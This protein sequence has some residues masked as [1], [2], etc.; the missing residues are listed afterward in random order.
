MRL[1][2]L[3][4]MVTAFSVRGYAQRYD[5]AF[6]RITTEDGMG[7]R[8]NYISALYQ[9]EKGFIWVGNSSG[10]Q[11][12]DGHNFVRFDRGNRGPDP[13]P[14]VAINK[15]LPAGNGKLWLGAY[16]T[17]QFGIF[18]PATGSYVDV[19][20]RTSSTMPARS[21]FSLWQDAYGNT[22]I[23]VF[24]YGR[25]LQYD[26][27]RKEFNERTFLNQLPPGWKV[28]LSA[29]HD[30]RRR[31]YW[32]VC[33][34]GLAVYDEASRQ[35]WHKDHN[36]ANLPLLNNTAVQRAVSKF[37]IDGQGRYWIVNWANHLAIHCFDASGR[38][39][40]DTAGLLSANSGYFEP[41][42][43]YESGNG[44]L[45]IYGIA[46]LY[47]QDSGAHR[48]N[49]YGTQTNN[50]FGIRY[51]DVK[52]V[53]EDR[54]G[55]HWIATD[56]GLFYSSRRNRTLGNV[57]LS[58]VPG[59]FSVTDIL[60]LKTGQYWVSTWGEGVLTMN[61]N[62]GFYP[63]PLYKDMPATDLTTKVA[64]RQ[65]W[66]LHQQ[67]TTGRIFIGCQRGQ[68]MIY[69]TV[70]RKTQYLHPPELELS[71]IRSMSE[72][73]KGEILIG[74]QNGKLFL[75][76]GATFRKLTDMGAGAIVYKIIVDRD[77][78]VWVG[79]QDMGVYAIDP[80]N[81][82]TVY[83][84]STGKGKNALFNGTCTDVEQLT[85]DVIVA[86]TSALTL[87]NKR[88]GEIRTI[89]ASEGL[90]SNSVK[91]LRVDTEGILWMVTDNGLSRYDHRRNTFT[92]YGKV[93]G[94]LFGDVVRSADHRC[95]D[96]VLMFSGVN[97]LLFF[98]PD[99]LKTTRRTPDVTFTEF[100]INDTPVSLDSLSGLQEITIRQ[101]QNDFSIHFACLDFRN[102]HKYSYYYRLKGLDDKWIRSDALSVS[103]KGLAPGRYELGVKAVN[104]EGV[105]SV[106]ISTLPIFV[107][108]PF[109]MTGWFISAIL[110]FIVFIAYA[111]HLMRI[112]R[113]MAVEKVRNRVARDLHDDMGST[114]STI[115]ILSAMA[116]AKL[117]TDAR[118]TGEYI[119]KISDN[120][121]RMM[122]AMDDIVWA[123]KPANDSMQKV[124]GR[125]REFATS[126]FEAKDIELEFIA[127]KEVNEVKI[128]MEARRDFFL[129][130]KEAVNNAAKYSGCKKALV[131]IY[132]EQ[133]KLMLLV[134]DDGR[135]FDV[136]QADSG[137]GL[138]NMQK[139][140]DTLRARIQVESKPGEG[141]SV[142]LAVPVN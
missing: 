53:M 76:D 126:V 98:H 41:N 115:N 107:R 23:S 22:F 118:R 86:A 51:E 32:I 64:Y 52:Q 122:E 130:F 79:T 34:Q 49:F 4:V 36:P 31:Q 139:R 106:H 97:N 105:E 113:L 62:F 5:R 28:H 42:H 73:K 15:I 129:I 92:S 108:P 121:Q 63:S 54:D 26:T 123:I 81:G 59:K 56:Q 19:P 70:T 69:D 74:T 35:L 17:R 7:L 134:R 8:S 45:W 6:I 120:S 61:R 116:K 138:G 43:F 124:V 44:N 88:T 101:W 29:H 67:S 3:L 94:V 100:Y 71:T 119:N 78:L 9:D 46:N 55:I 27:A 137:N 77:G 103:F 11:R 80:N 140:A 96:D 13:I 99:A 37:Y 136:K 93:D 48:F 20:L 50:E 132:V 131:H 125:M 102:R 65:V 104:T 112:K 117:N 12:F 75:Y 33:E 114:L 24:R 89:T 57:V 135:G 133:Q 109:W 85:D 2:V 58:E 72:T 25:I 40:R 128:D 83:H 95:S 16:G 68:I 14:T 142:H 21:E 66:A 91:R 127:S 141:C 1:A 87:I 84:F 47:V 60:E 39:L 38:A 10:L 18:D 111:M 110:T 82:R 90:P 30:L